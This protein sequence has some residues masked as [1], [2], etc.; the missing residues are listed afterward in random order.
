MTIKGSG[1]YRAGC[2]SNRAATCNTT[3]TALKNLRGLRG[4]PNQ[5]GLDVVRM[6][7]PSGEARCGLYTS[8]LTTCHPTHSTF[9]EQAAPRC[10]RTSSGLLPSFQTHMHT[11]PADLCSDWAQH[12]FVTSY[13]QCSWLYTCWLAVANHSTDLDL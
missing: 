13:S 10:T 2:V 8:I 4:I 6:K 3:M 12:E 7:L 9:T 1:R 11:S 5:E